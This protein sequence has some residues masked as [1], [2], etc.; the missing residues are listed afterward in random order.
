MFSEELT[1]FLVMKSSNGY[2]ADKVSQR[3]RPKV[4]ACMQRGQANRDDEW[5][6]AKLF[7]RSN[8]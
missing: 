3:Q 4:C 1:R 7:R 5:K 2:H 8:R 6:Q